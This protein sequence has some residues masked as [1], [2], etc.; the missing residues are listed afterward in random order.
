[1]LE[2]FSRRANLVIVESEGIWCPPTPVTDLFKAWRNADLGDIIELHAS[3]PDIER[4]VRAWA[5]KSGN[6]VL[7]VRHE[8]D[9]TIIVIRI[10]KRGKETTILPASKAS[11]DDPDETKITP[12]AKL[13]LVTVGGF[14]MGLRTLDPGWRWTTSMQPIAKTASCQ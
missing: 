14:A 3:E 13:Q 9:R 6:K 12:K 7:E 1:M 2:K 11:M 5:H 8:R 10:T 4:D